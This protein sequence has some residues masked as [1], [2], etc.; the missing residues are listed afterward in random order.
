[1]ERSSQFD[2]SL[3]SSIIQKETSTLN[4]WIV[5]NNNIDNSSVKYKVS[6]N[7]KDYL[8]QQHY[9]MPCR[10]NWGVFRKIYDIQPR[11]Y[12]QLISI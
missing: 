10:L 6:N 4:G 7:K 1:M 9:E 8:I 12:E 3:P 11:N 5:A 2:S